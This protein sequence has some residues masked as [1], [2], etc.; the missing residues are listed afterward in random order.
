M[1]KQKKIKKLLI[2]LPIFI[3]VI[4]CSY[5]VYKFKVKDNIYKDNTRVL[6]T[7]TQ[8]LELNTVKYNYSN[9]ITVKKDKSFNNVKIPFTNKSFIIK[10]NGVINGG[11][12]PEDISIVKN[13]GDEITIEIEQCRIL[14]HYVDDESIYIYDVN[15]SIFNKLEIQEVLD[16]L[17]KYKE[18]Y[19]EKIINE[20]FMEEIK[21]NTK[22]SLV[23]MLNNMGYEE[24]TVTFNE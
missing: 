8:V 17:N 21:S 11:I 7:I 1:Q 2:L 6:N 20:G 24:I 3:S 10:Y 19:E 9:V 16:D 5:I 22:V 18:E 15:S 4:S 12:K 14:D 13:T 23:N